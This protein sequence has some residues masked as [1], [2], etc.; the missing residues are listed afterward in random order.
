MNNWYVQIEN[1]LEG[2]PILNMIFLILAV[3]GIVLTFYFYYKSNKRKEPLYC[4]VTNNLITESIPRINKF[5]ILYSGLEIKN[6]SISRIAIW[7][8]G[9]EP[10]RASDIAVNA[11]ITVKIDDKFQILDCNIIFKKHKVNDFKTKISNDKKSIIVSFDY[12]DF[13]EGL[14][15]EV[16]HTGNTSNDL[17]VNGKIISVK[18][19]RRK[20]Y[21]NPIF[22]FDVA[23]LAKIQKLIIRLGARKRVFYG[24]FLIIMACIALILFFFVPPNGEKFWGPSFPLALLSQFLPGVLLAVVGYNM[25][26]VIIP[27][28]F[29][30]FSEKK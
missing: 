16:F 28:D 18:E 15:M 25:T 23:D 4:I 30:L 1:F 2:N 9:K 22:P 8:K 6:L 5:S 27:V 24:R 26:K 13:E 14:I 21:S 12:F 19:I 10:I 20:E 17:Q 3:I 11:P 29:D 7:N